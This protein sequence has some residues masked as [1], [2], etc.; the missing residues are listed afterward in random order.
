MIIFFRRLREKFVG[1]GNIRR[2]LIYAVG[3]ILLVMIGILLALQ[4]NNW[5]EERKSSME[6]Q[7]LLSS[8]KEDFEVRLAE[9]QE[10][11]IARRQAIDAIHVINQIISEPETLPGD[12]AMDSILALSQ[13]ALTFNDQ[14]KT[15]DMLFSTGMINDL[16]NEELKRN[17]ILWPQQVEEMMEEQRARSASAQ[18]VLFPLLYEYVAMR[19][20]HE[21]FT[22]RD[23]NLDKGQPTTFKSNY[24]GLIR[25]PAYERYLATLENFLNINDIDSEILIRQAE[26]IIAQINQEMRD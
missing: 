22:F 12:A 16:S 24:S 2:Y 11:R 23:Y 18:N 4:V 8:L 3:E 14:F 21:K 20:V 15:L 10:F 25:E 1:E 9:L 5:N 6:E 13:N 19:E 26:A 7:F 17:L